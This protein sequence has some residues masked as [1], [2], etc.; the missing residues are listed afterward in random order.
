M[1]IS[2]PVTD[3]TT[4]IVW[5]STSYLLDANTD[6]T[7]GNT[8][9]ILNSIGWLCEHESAI[10]IHAKSMVEDTLIVPAGTVYTL[11]FLFVVLIPLVLLAAGIFITIRRRHK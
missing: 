11:S 8:D 5:Y 2:E 1:A 10:S 7:G 6:I 9:L 3:G 4:Q